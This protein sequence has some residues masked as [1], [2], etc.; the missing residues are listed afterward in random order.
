MDSSN[1]LWDIFHN[2]PINKRR[3]Y[4]VS[5]FPEFENVHPNFSKPS[6]VLI[7][8]TSGNMTAEFA[9]EFELYALMETDD[10]KLNIITY[11]LNLRNTLSITLYATIPKDVITNYIHN[12]QGESLLLILGFTSA[13]V[14][15]NDKDNFINLVVESNM[16]GFVIKEFYLSL[17]HNAKA[18]SWLR[19]IIKV[20]ESISCIL[21]L[22]YAAEKSPELI[23]HSKYVFDVFTEKGN[24]T[25][26]EIQ[27]LFYVR[28]SNILYLI[29][30]SSLI[31]TNSL[32]ELYY[33]I[34]F[35]SG[36]FPYSWFVDLY[37]KNGDKDLKEWLA[38]T[39]V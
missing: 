4:L 29:K 3:E 2:V 39:D 1:V 26:D 5:H 6:W 9:R 7:D 28:D 14:A 23:I 34:L 37:E 10:I 8:M 32:I 19:D 17:K 24:Y 13:I 35:R 22:I 27:R 15:N 20:T 12:Y 25:P 30:T 21:N 18:I 11:C 33:E 36:Y 16:D 31:Y 38:I